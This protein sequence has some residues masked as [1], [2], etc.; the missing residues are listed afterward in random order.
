MSRNL[1]YLLVVVAFVMLVLVY[2]GTP[3]HGVRPHTRGYASQ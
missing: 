1:L 2:V 3:N